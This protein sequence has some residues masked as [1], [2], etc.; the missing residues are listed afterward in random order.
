VTRGLRI[1]R[2]LLCRS[3]TW[4]LKIRAAKYVQDQLGHGDIRTTERYY[5]QLERQVKAEGAQATEVAIAGAVREHEGRRRSGY[6]ARRARAGV[7]WAGRT[8][9]VGCAERP[10]LHAALA[11][12]TQRS[13]SSGW[14]R[15]GPSS[16]PILIDGMRPRFA[17]S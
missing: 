17:A 5:G 11:S 10:G 7:R 9:A 8:V 12:L 6:A 15:S 16:P 1:S 3:A 14:N 13:T 2:R 4:N